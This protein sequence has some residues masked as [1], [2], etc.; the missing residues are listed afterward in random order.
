MSGVIYA[1]PLARARDTAAPVARSRD[2]EIR[3]DEDLLEF[4]SGDLAGQWLDAA[5]SVGTD[6]LERYGPQQMLPD[7]ANWCAVISAA[8][9]AL[10]AHAAELVRGLRDDP[11]SG[12][13]QGLLQLS[14]SVNHL[15]D[16]GD[17]PGV[18]DWDGPRHGPLELGAGA[19]LATL[20]RLASQ[21]PE[22]S[23]DTAAAAAAPLAAA[24]DLLETS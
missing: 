6:G 7:L 1:S 10:G 11:P 16:L 3:L 21:H 5:A 2:L 8:D 18:L 19:F 13:T 23:S 24:D 22:L 4:D 15:V 17:G 12:R 20:V 14:F 9:P